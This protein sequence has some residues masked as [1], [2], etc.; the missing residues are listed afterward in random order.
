[1]NVLQTD[2]AL[3]Y[4]AVNLFATAL[5]D[6]DSSQVIQHYNQGKPSL[7]NRFEIVGND[8]IHSEMHRKIVH[9][10]YFILSLIFPFS[11][12]LKAP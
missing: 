4:D 12:I 9:P 3:L 2:T 1:M 7:N 10:T 8:L 5:S 6:L 11:S